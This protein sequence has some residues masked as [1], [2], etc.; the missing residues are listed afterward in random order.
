MWLD[1]APTELMALGSFSLVL[2]GLLLRL[3]VTTP[4]AKEHLT[5][6]AL[7]FT[8]LTL[9]LITFHSARRA[10]D[11]RQ[12]SERI[13]VVLGNSEKTF[14]QVLAEVRT[15]GLRRFSAAFEF[16]ETKGR[17]DS[18]LEPVQLTPRQTIQ[19]RL[20]RVVP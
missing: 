10:E 14:D 1:L 12:I 7:V 18:R 11:V 4:S 9:G 16:L 19:V 8:V 13:V 15:P 20:W 6:A 3:I 2:G 17:L 5:A